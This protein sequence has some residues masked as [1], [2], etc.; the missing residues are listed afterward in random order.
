[1]IWGLGVDFVYSVCRDL[2]LPRFLG[3]ELT[4]FVDG[5]MWFGPRWSS[6]INDDMSKGKFATDNV[7]RIETLCDTVSSHDHLG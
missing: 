2:G 6:S 7:S 4:L 5:Q 1:M 3:V